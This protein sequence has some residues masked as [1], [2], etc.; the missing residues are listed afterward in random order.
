M[1]L[2]P[3][4]EKISDKNIIADYYSILDSAY[5]SN[6]ENDAAFQY[7]DKALELYIETENFYKTAQIRASL[8]SLNQTI[9]QREGN[10]TALKSMIVEFEKEIEFAKNHK[11]KYALSFNTRHLAQIYLPQI[12]D[13]K[14]AEELFLESLSLREEI[15]FKPYLPASYFSL[16]EVADKTENYDKAIKMYKK[17]FN[18]ADEIGFVRYQFTARLKIAE[19]FQKQDRINKAREYYAD[20]LKSASSNGYLTGIEEALQKIEALI[21]K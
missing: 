21:K 8:I 7:F 1:D 13:Y 4:S 15:G 11:N 12:N 20:A 19:I 16:G 9:L 17:S 5:F 6:K 2:K 14:K 10:S 3:I 18:L